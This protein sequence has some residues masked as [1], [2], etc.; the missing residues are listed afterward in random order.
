MKDKYILNKDHLTSFLRRI[1]RNARLIA[2]V[3]NPQGDT[4]FAEIHSL[5]RTEIDLANQPQ[6]SAKSFFFPPRETLF[7]FTSSAPDSYSFK[8]VYSGGEPT[9]YFGLRSCDLSAILYMDVIFRQHAKDPYYL[10]RRRNSILISIGCNDPFANCFC[11]ATRNGPFPEY[12]YDLQFTDL[13]DR[14]FVQPDRAKGEE[15]IRKWGYFFKPATTEDIR[16][17]YQLSLEARGNFKQRVDAELAIKRLL[18]NEVPAG[19]FEELSKRCQDCGGCAYICPT[20]TCFSITDRSTDAH[21]G[22]RLRIWDACTFSGFSKM[23]GGH[24]PVSRRTQAVE[25]RFRHKL[26]HDVEKHGR[27]SCVGCGR[28]VGM[29]FDGVDIIRFINSV[30]EQNQLDKEK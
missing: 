13:G 3:K 2:P 11:N 26:Q 5:D 1:K 29:C 25:K 10:H 6:T 18:A 28:C 9:I 4:M 30:C 8:P 22:E 17:Q 24:N 15:L 21:G 12:G 23:A 27:S 20:C 19:I 14:F 7:T 16:D